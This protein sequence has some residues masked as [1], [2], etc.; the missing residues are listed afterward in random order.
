MFKLKLPGVV[1]DLIIYV[2][3]DIIQIVVV[4]YFIA[5]GFTVVLVVLIFLNRGL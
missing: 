4:R 1:H 2:G 3:D 5:K